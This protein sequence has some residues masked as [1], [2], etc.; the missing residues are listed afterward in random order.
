MPRVTSSDGTAI[1]Y[2]C[3]SDGGPA[4]VLVGGG[5]DDGSENSAADPCLPDAHRLT[6]DVAGHVADPRVLGPHLAHFSTS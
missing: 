4:V 2:D 3:L 1:G 6:I 5:L